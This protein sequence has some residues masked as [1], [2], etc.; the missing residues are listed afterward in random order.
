MRSWVLSMMSFE[1][2]R[3]A[4]GLNCRVWFEL[5]RSHRTYSNP[6][7]AHPRGAARP[8]AGG[9][10]S[11]AAGEGGLREARHHPRRQPGLPGEREI[12]R[13]ARH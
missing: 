5:S 10:H 2:G 12:V 6:G 4:F 13:T 7:E 11:G 3:G 8:G 1:S 9:A